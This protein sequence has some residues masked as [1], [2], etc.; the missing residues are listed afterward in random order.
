MIDAIVRSLARLTVTRRN[1]LEW[2]T[3]AQAK[4]SQDTDLAGFYRQ[5][6]GGVA[7]ALAA[8]VLVLLAK[9]TTA[10]IATL[11]IGLWL[12][13][14]LIARWV[15]LPPRKSPAEQLSA[16]DRTALR[17]TARRTWRYF[18]T[19]V[20]PAEHAL[21]PDNYQ[22]D[23]E[24]LIAHRTSPTNI[25]I[26]LLATVTARDL[27]WIGTLEM[28]ERLEATL[29]T[30][31]QLEQFRGHLF[32]WYDTRDLHRLEPAYV[33]AVDSGNLAGH[34]LTLSNACRQMIDQP[35]PLAAALAGIGDALVL[36]RQAAG[37]I[38]HDRRS[39]TLGR[40]HLEEALEAPEAAVVGLP[41]TPETWA[42]GLG[43][44]ATYTQTLSDVATTLTA[45]RGEGAQGELVTWAEAARLAVDSHLRD[46][47][48]LRSVPGTP[49]VP[50][51]AELSRP[52]DGRRPRRFP[53]RGAARPAPPGDR[54]A[55]PATLPRDE[56][57]LP[58][59][60]HAQAPLDR[61][62]NHD[63]ALDTSYYD[64]LAS[65]A[66]LTSFLA[67]AKGDVTADHWF[68]LG[69]A[70]AG[71]SWLGVDRGPARCSIPHA[72]PRDALAGYSLLDKTYQLIVARQVATPSSA[73]SPGASPSPG[74]TPA[75]SNQTHPVH[76]LRLPGSA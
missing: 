19:F 59:R 45:E 68:R 11:F 1:L 54:R 15:S 32:N 71:R 38:R 51:L 70:D 69:L 41:A 75:T 22:D 30:V 34:L 25:G 5:M 37:A 74:S 63:G 9:P 18:E 4:A 17:L 67:I 47:A 24:P 13:S 46:L 48:L 36:A 20:T 49:D 6:A 65:E 52:S 35:L 56:L 31:A 26:Y 43:G 42:A 44:L 2:T 53:G 61:L 62:G 12:V 39:Q 60:P 29:A 3:A 23:P 14:P 55:G 21:P 28:V 57:H 66:R 73:A 72:H 10:W 16:R 27:G 7:I 33:S 50:T 58:V 64:I 40:R 8:A 76:E